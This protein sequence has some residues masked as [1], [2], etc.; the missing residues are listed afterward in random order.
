MRGKRRVVALVRVVATG[1]MLAVLV[2]RV[3]ITS[4]V[5]QWD[6]DTVGW[7]GRSIDDILGRTDAELFPTESG[8][9]IIALKREALATG[10]SARAEVCF[11]SGASA[12]WRSACARSHV[13]RASWPPSRSRRGGG[14]AS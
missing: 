13:C 6:V 12:R 1:A 3:H 7:L 11:D 2:S 4:L 14:P 5:P 9:T 10:Q 8:A